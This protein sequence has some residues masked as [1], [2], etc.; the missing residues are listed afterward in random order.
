MK[1][2]VLVTRHV[3]PAALAILQEHCVVDYQDRTDVMDEAELQRR[4]R[5]AQGVVCQLTDPI[6]RAVIDAA[7][8]LRVIAQIAV[9]HDNVDVRAATARRPS[10]T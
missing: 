10:M 8:E 3:Y 1:P 5:L 6:S 4:L 2:R 9:G 7:P